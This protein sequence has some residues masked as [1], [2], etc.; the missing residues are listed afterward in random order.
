MTPALGLMAPSRARQVGAT[1]LCIHASCRAPTHPLPNPSTTT[2]SAQ[3]LGTQVDAIIASED[4]QIFADRLKEIDEKLAPSFAVNT[5]ADA[6]KAA[7]TIGYPVMIRSAFALGGLGSGI[8]IDE[9]HL[10]DMCS[11]ALSLSPQVL[12]EKSL[13]GWKEVEYEVVRDSADNCITVCNMENFDPLGVHTGDS[14]VVAPSQTLSNAE[15]QMLRDTALKVI[16][17]FGIVGECNIQYALDPNSMDYCIIEINARLSRSSAL[18]SKATGYPLASVAA[19][20]SLGVTLPEVTNAIT[21]STTA[22]FEPSLDYIVT[23]IPRWDLKKF[24]S[25]VNCEIGSAMK[26]VGEVMSIG[27]TW[28]ESLQKAL[29][30]VDSSIEGFEPRGDWSQPGALLQELTR[31][32]DQRVYAIAHALRHKIYSVDELHDLTAIDRWFLYRLAGINTVGDAI[33]ATSLLSELSPAAMLEAKQAGFSDRQIAA[34]LRGT[35]PAAPAVRPSSLDVRAARKAAGITPFVK[36]IDT[37]AAEYPAQTNY[38]YTTYHATCHDMTFGDRG[39]M[40]L[41]SGTYRIGSSVEFDWC[42]VSAIRTLRRI[43][44]KTIVVNY[45]P[46]TV[47]TDFDECDRLYFEELSLE[48]VMDIYE[49]EQ[50]DGVIVSVGGQIPNNLAL[51]LSRAGLRILGTSAASIDMAEDRAKFSVLM[52]SIGVRQ[53]CPAVR[54]MGSAAGVGGCR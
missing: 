46:E 18:A 30:M 1:V 19:K 51:P 32:T 52:D 2:V 15:Y 45:N 33:A 42:S 21:R 10:E 6:K 53:V 47:S 38:L 27:R 36:Q 14:I 50:A 16:R 23:K 31:P 8:C 35:S 39:V 13:K 17:H 44:H 28:A 11:K 4:R 9:A 48:R 29:R 40:V 43:G 25:R 24:G 5:V 41:G 12:V 26:S 3:V 49:A 34:R 54:R 20:L 7:L 22:C 37:L